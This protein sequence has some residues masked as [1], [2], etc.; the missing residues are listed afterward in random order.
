MKEGKKFDI[1][2]MNPPYARSLCNEF[3]EKTLNV[4]NKVITV[5]PINWLTGRK[6]NTKITNLIDGFE[7][8]IEL[9][10]GNNFF[11]AVFFANVSINCVNLTKLGNIKYADNEYAKC[12][13]IKSYS[14]DRY[15]TEFVEKL[16]EVK[17]SLW[18]MINFHK[19][20]S[21]RDTAKDDDYCIKIAR[22]R[23]HVSSNANKESKDF[24]TIIS[25]ND[26]FIKTQIGL[27]KNLKEIPNKKGKFNFRYFAFKHEKELNNFI[28]YIKT[29]FVRTCLRILKCY[30]ELNKGCLENV[31]WQDFSD[32]VF[33]KSPKEID[34]YLFN[35]Y[36]ISYE[37]KTHLQNSLPDYY[38]IRK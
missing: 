30:S 38:E 33:S 19:N 25:N 23:G 24:Y 31:P 18:D 36:N 10:N 12:S 22:I 7:T 34:D 8:D 27:Y 2:I 16:G 21:K 37:L 15:L 14:H 1:C 26:K 3:F 35:K 6:Q 4:C 29:D 11:D 17:H 5:Q 28:N 32:D 20:N 13:Y 9:I